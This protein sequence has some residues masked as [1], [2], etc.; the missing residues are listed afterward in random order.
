MNAKIILDAFPN[1]TYSGKVSRVS[2][3]PTETSGVVSYEAV[4]ELSIDR[5]DIFSKMSV[6]VEILTTEKNNVLTIPTAAIST[7]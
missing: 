2:E 7:E 3:V 4:V 5:T 6:T 1:E